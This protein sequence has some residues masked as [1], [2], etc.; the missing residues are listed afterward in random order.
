MALNWS[1]TISAVDRVI[2]FI[3]PVSDKWKTVMTDLKQVVFDRW[4]SWY[5]ELVNNILCNMTKKKQKTERK[6]KKVK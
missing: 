5:L 4:F 1:F 6:E 3:D 2:S